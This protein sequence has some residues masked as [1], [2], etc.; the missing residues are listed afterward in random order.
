MVTNAAR[1][2]KQ[3]GQVVFA[4]GMNEVFWQ[5]QLQMSNPLTATHIWGQYVERKS[6]KEASSLESLQFASPEEEESSDSTSCLRPSLKNFLSET[7]TA[8]WDPP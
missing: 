4:G 8:G 3:R 1:T 5:R 6:R 2:R 7:P